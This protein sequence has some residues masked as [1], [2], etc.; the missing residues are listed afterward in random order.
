MTIVHG[1]CLAGYKATFSQRAAMIVEEQRQDMAMAESESADILDA[2]QLDIIHRFSSD[3]GA[4]YK[5]AEDSDD[6]SDEDDESK[7]E[8]EDNMMEELAAYA[9]AKPGCIY[10]AYQNNRTGA[11]PHYS[12]AGPNAPTNKDRTKKKEEKKKSLVEDTKVDAATIPATN[13]HKSKRERLSNGNADGAS[14]DKHDS[15]N[16]RNVGRDREGCCINN[17]KKNE[18]TGLV[19]SNK[20]VTPCKVE[21]ATRD[22]PSNKGNIVEDR[23]EGKCSRCKNMVGGNNVLKDKRKRTANDQAGVAS[24]D[25]SV[26]TES[27]DDVSALQESCIKNKKRKKYDSIAFDKS[28]NSLQSDVST[29]AKVSKKKHAD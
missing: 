28:S 27:C 9:L 20:I 6:D 23:K 12:S 25:E 15:N 19:K 5:G 18:K 4:K 29:T 16:S 14:A 13:K 17:K 22:V 1:F 11:C 8:E 26:R 10:C 7:D 21:K 3:R 24:M 2:K